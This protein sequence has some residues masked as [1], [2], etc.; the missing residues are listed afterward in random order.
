MICRARLVALQDDKYARVEWIPGPPADGHVPLGGPGVQDLPLHLIPPDFRVPNS[1][2]MVSLEDRYTVLSV[3]PIEEDGMDA[4]PEQIPS[5][6]VAVERFRDFLASYGHAGSLVWV[7]RED[8]YMPGT[9]EIVIKTPV[10][11]ANRSLAEKVFEEGREQ[12]LVAVTALAR[13]DGAIVTSVWFPK[14]PHEEVQGWN[15]NLKLSLSQPLPRAN[16]VRSRVLWWLHQQRPAYRRFQ[17]LYGLMGTREW[18]A[19]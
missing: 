8:L 6:S 4:E 5:F 18:A 19:A 13:L 15:Q 17:E 16:A 11:L 1:E 14:Y 7:F 2:F 9:D 3:Q 10:P 12:G